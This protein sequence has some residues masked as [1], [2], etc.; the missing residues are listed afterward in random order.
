MSVRLLIGVSSKGYK[1]KPT[2]LMLAILLITTTFITP[3]SSSGVQ[4][5]EEK[6]R[7]IEAVLRRYMENYS[8]AKGYKLYYIDV[9]LEGENF[10][11]GLLK[12][13]A[14]RSTSVKEV[15]PGKY[16]TEQIKREG[17]I[18]LGIRGIE[19]INKSKVKVYGLTFASSFGEGLNWVHELKRR[20]RNWVITD[21]ASLNLG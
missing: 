9:E 11:K 15:E 2:K 4:S 12:R 1:V 14:Q 3:V 18:V 7:I 5:R 6:Y 17:G 16:D 19:R 10:T 13:L 20:G 21:E 8:S